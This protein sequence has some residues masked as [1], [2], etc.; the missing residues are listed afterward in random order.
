MWVSPNSAG[1]VIDA[2][3][4][5]KLALDHGLKGAL[6]GPSSYFK[7]SPPVQ[8]PDDQARALVEEFIVKYGRKGARG[9]K[10][11]RTPKPRAK[12]KAKAK[13]AKAAPA[14][15]AARRPTPAPAKKAVR[16]GRK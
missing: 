5:A 3:R 9:A 2:V 16:R 4:C 1:V 15:K 13:A 14:A 6:I 10:P 8:Y 12:A 7:K 11:A